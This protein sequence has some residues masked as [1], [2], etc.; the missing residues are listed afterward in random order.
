MSNLFLHCR[1]SRQSTGM[2]A[3]I[4]PTHKHTL[5]LVNILDIMYVILAFPAIVS[6]SKRKQQNQ[7][8]SDTVKTIKKKNLVQ[9][10]GTL[11]G[12]T[13]MAQ[14]HYFN[15]WRYYERTVMRQRAPARQRHG[16]SNNK[17][18]LD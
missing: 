6:R 16:E 7:R 15:K 13:S 14:G 3:L 4:Y 10:M 12:E 17:Q 1:F 9:G 11:V 8:R 2:S 5:F 18:I